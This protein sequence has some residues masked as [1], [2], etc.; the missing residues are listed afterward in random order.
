LP[1]VLLG[2]VLCL[3]GPGAGAAGRHAVASAHP[4][5][6]AAGE[7]VLASGGNAFDAA[8]AVAAALAVV[9]PFAS[10][11]GGG[12]FFLLHRASDGRQVMLDAR[13]TA[14]G[15]ASADMYL[16][17]D[18][19]P[20]T[21]ASLDGARAAGIPGVPAGLVHL[22]ERYGTRPLPTLLAPAIGLAENGFGADARYVAAIG[23]RE[24]VLR[25]FDSCWSLG[26][27]LH[28]GFSL[29]LGLDALL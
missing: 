16:G 19:R 13:E 12:G 25:Y 21:R 20:D 3:A 4:L 22:A 29:D 28:Q 23:W 15:A 14:P 26:R 2:L 6:T 18:G 7:A 8:V 1:G 10:G 17:A 27:L 5:A 11:L 9:E 24:T